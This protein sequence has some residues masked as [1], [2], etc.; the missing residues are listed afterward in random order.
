MLDRVLEGR[1]EEI[2]ERWVELV[3]ASY[4]QETS[5]FL[6]REK[7]PF[8]NPVGRLVREAAGPLV[9]ALG[10]DRPGPEAMRHLDAL[11]RLRSVQDVTAGDAVGVVGLL[12]RAVLD[13]LGDEGGELGAAGMLELSER[14]ER[15]LLAA[16]EVFT[17][18]REQLHEVRARELARRQAS[19]LRRAERLVE[20]QRKEQETEEESGAGG[21]AGPPS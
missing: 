4:P 1:Q 5:R 10:A 6:E 16:F 3:F 18:C 15:M 21:V 8:A 2:A 7:D 9:A 19:L 11:M 20:E 13:V 17:A 14:V 12:R